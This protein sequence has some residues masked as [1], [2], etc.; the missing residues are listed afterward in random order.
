MCTSE[1]SFTSSFYYSMKWMV[2]WIVQFPLLNLLFYIS[3]YSE[4]TKGLNDLS[5]LVLNSLVFL[6]WMKYFEKQFF[7]ACVLFKTL[8]Y[9]QRFCSIRNYKKCKYLLILKYSITILHLAKK[10]CLC[11]KLK[12]SHPFIFTAWL[13][14]PLIY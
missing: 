5:R 1:L 14:K 4:I 3:M 12:L 2:I 6:R 9:K 7:D 11:Q 8:T 13:C 10:I